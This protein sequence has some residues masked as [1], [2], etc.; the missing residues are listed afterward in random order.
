MA[1]GST[2]FFKATIAEWAATAGKDDPALLKTF[3][4]ANHAVDDAFD[5]CISWMK[6]ELLPRS[7]GTYA[8]GAENYSRKLLYDDMIDTPLDELL[9]TGE[10]NLEKDYRAFIETARQIDPAK[11]PA[12]VMHAIAQDHP[13]ESDLLPSTRDTIDRICRFIK[14]RGIVTMPTD[15]PPQIVETPPYAR[16]GVFAMMDTPGAYEP[17][18]KEAYYYVTPTEPEWDAQHKEEHLRLFNRPVMEVITIHEAYPGHY[19]QFLYANRFPTKTRKLLWCG[20]NVEGWAHYTEQM[21]LDEGYGDGDPKLRLA[22]LH[23]ALLRDV[24]YVVGIKLHTQGMTVEEG[25]RMFVEKGHQEP[26]TAYEEARRGAYN[27]TYLYYTLGKL[28][29]YKLREDYRR[30]RGD[31]YRLQDFHDELVRQGGIPI[32]LLSKIM[33]KGGKK[34]G[35]N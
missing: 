10:A 11:T 16:S 22:Q 33:L 4:A 26:S 23:E 32:P 30:A 9:A 20:T 13:T 28:L 3:E 29:I 2:G 14:E 1:E 8:I 17:R 18:A 27:P 25:A 35:K 24:R 6:T 7:N 12:E 34:G 21:M 5:K 15:V 31:A 19:V